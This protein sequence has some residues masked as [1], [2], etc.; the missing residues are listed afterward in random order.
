MGEDA[1]AVSNY[2]TD[3]S[4]SSGTSLGDLLKAQIG[5]GDEDEDDNN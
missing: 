1:E 2:R 3:S 4:G 5:S